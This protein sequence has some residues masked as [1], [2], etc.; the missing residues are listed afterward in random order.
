MTPHPLADP[1]DPSDFYGIE[2]A[3]VS[4][5]ESD[6]LVDPDAG[7]GPKV[8]RRLAQALTATFNDRQ[9][10]ADLEARLAELRAAR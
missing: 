1:I 8:R 5:L 3:I 2:D 9:R 6:N 10:I 4:A 7:L